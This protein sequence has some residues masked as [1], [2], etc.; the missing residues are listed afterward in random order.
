M[1]KTN[2]ELF[3]VNSCRNDFLSNKFTIHL[4]EERFMQKA[5]ENFLQSGELFKTE[6]PGDPFKLKL[7]FLN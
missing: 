1:S 2:R 7:N 4:L 5:A 3:A 6:P